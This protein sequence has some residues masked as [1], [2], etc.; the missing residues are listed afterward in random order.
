MPL[1]ST[2]RGTSG[3]GLVEYGLIVGLIA[4]IVI[5]LFVALGPAIR[6]MFSGSGEERGTSVQTDTAPVQPL[7]TDTQ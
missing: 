3:Q 5:A 1:K 2:R 4:I 6:K 7:E